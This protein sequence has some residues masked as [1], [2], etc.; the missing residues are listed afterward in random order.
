V[1]IGQKGDSLADIPAAH[2]AIDDVRAVSAGKLRRYHGEGWRQL[3]DLKTMWLNFR[4]GFRVLAGCWQAYW[5]LGTLK[6]EII[7][8]K[9]GFVGVPVGLAAVL[10]HI[11][12]ITHDSD[13]V[14]GLAN[15]LIGRWARTHAVALP[16]EMY[17]Y[18]PHKTVTVGVP[19]GE[20]YQS[21]DAALQA[22]Y[23]SETGLEAYDRVLVVT[24]GG[25]GA[26]RLNTALIAIAPQLL[27]D[28]P[29]LAIVH[30]AGRANETE[31][32]GG[33]AAAVPA[34]DEARVKVLGYTN[35]LYRYTGAADLV[36]MR[37][38]ATAIA[39]CAVQGKA[40]ILAP[41]PYLTAGHQLKN[42]QALAEQDAVEVVSEQT[43]TD[44]PAVLLVQIRNLLQSAERRAELGSH[45]RQLAHPDS[46]H[47][48]A[49]VLLKEAAR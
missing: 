14:P 7:F 46:A 31:V 32:R 41:N 28:F 10:R 29:G 35:D 39:E 21:V 44:N 20:A 38:G 42:A 24:G 23:R 5:L 48:L 3:L 40:V 2:G 34:G 25:L 17:Q 15:R 19:V 18:P 43:L 49:M 36:V 1:Y 6:P 45:L 16:K 22:T 13:A 12:Y 26:Q 11:P 33:Y 9:G 37:A 8:I 47:E 4:D 27:A 30:T